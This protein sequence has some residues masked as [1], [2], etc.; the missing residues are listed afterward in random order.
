MNFKFNIKPN[1]LQDYLKNKELYK[2]CLN[3]KAQTFIWLHH[4][5]ATCIVFGW[6]SDSPT[7]LFMS[8][9]FAGFMVYLWYL[10]NN[11]CFMTEIHIE[12][13]QLEPSFQLRDLVYMV[14]PKVLP[15]KI[16][17]SL[18]VGVIFIYFYRIKSSLKNN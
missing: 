16:Q 3:L 4:F 8:L 9:L 14:Y 5:I 6:L 2:T 10:N 15:R 11:K 18:I 12:D 13:C 1:D 17:L 7:F